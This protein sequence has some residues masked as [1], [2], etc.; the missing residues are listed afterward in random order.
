MKGLA[1]YYYLILFET[2][3]TFRPLSLAC[4]FTSSESEQAGRYVI[5]GHSWVES[6]CIPNDS[7]FPIVVFRLGPH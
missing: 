1:M 6:A 4:V 2:D 3:C 5:R 7:V